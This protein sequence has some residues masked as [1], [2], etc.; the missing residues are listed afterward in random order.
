MLQKKKNG[1][2]VR[3]AIISKN[4]FNL[5]HIINGR[6]SFFNINQ[7]FYF[8]F[9]CY[10]LV[11]NVCCIMFMFLTWASCIHLE[12]SLRF[13]V[14]HFVIVCCL[15]SCQ[16]LIVFLFLVIHSHCDIVQGCQNF[17]RKPI[18]RAKQWQPNYDCKI[19]NREDNFGFE[20]NQLQEWLDWVQK[21]Q[22]QLLYAM[23]RPRSPWKDLKTCF[24]SCNFFFRTK[25]KY[26]KF[27]AK[28]NMQ[29]SAEIFLAQ[30]C[31][32][33]SIS[34]KE[35]VSLFWSQKNILLKLYAQ[36]N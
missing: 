27:W 17:A 13:V 30:E 28:W 15:F 5:W 24:C 14:I 23:L 21:H 32:L 10:S 12:A 18:E 35:T 22:Y 34:R 19:P 26:S 16:H 29:N 9:L 1:I 36:R 3:S 20:R 6:I 11:G 7:T 31:I 2:F 33:F 25:I 4:L 8:F